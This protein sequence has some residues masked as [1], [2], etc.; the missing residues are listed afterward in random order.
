MN[1]NNNKNDDNNIDDNNVIYITANL[2]SMVP[3]VG[4]MF[5]KIL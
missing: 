5:E 4:T 2:M 1:A 3:L